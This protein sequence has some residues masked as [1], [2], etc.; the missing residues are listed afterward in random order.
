VQQKNVWERRKI[1]ILDGKSEIKFSDDF[2]M[3]TDELL[4][5]VLS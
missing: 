1:G 3:A 5:F 4:A 2:E